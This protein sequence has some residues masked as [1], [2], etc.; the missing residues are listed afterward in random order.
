MSF[1]FL[2]RQPYEDGR[3]H[4]EYICLDERHEQFEAVHEYTENDCNRTE[5]SVDRC[6]HLCRKED[7]GHYSQDH[8]M[9]RQDIG[10]SLTM[11]LK[12]L[13]NMP[14]ISIAGING[15]G[16]F[17]QVGTSGQRISFQ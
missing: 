15:T 9:T 17:N 16:T 14:M 5:P 8:E 7:Y 6:T 11:R 10:E 2:P 1:R 4:G 3:E 12:G 13:V